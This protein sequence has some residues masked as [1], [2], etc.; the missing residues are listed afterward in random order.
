M[1]LRE[2]LHTDPAEPN[3]EHLPGALACRQNATVSHARCRETALRG[4]IILPVRT[5]IS[6]YACLLMTEAVP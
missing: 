4:Q 3:R 6:C 5:G 2:G 1:K